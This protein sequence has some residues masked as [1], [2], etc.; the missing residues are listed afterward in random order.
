V[1]ARALWLVAL[2]VLAPETALACASCAWSAFGDRSYNWAFVGMLVLPFV[3]VG[4]IG[5]LIV[6]EVRRAQWQCEAQP[7]ASRADESERT[8]LGQGTL[9]PETMKE[10]T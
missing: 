4:V 1:R 6:R 2:V 5:G 3:V 9:P 8:R 7:K 10:R